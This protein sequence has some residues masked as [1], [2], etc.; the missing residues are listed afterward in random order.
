MIAFWRVSRLVLVVAM[1]KG[2]GNK[3]VKRKICRSMGWASTKA[4]MVRG[5]RKR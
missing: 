1:I 2:V 3:A 5:A 4:R